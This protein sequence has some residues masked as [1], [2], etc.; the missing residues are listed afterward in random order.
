[1]DQ[2]TIKSYQ[3]EIISILEKVGA[4]ISYTKDLGQYAQLM[5]K[6][7]HREPIINIEAALMGQKFGIVIGFPI[8]YEKIVRTDKFKIFHVTDLEQ[9]KKDWEIFFQEKLKT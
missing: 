7:S 5:S 4:K 1:M 6:L 8:G 3:Q 9:F 2:K